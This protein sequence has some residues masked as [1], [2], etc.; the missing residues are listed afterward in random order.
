[1]S[2]YILNEAAESFQQKNNS[3]ETNLK[4]EQLIYR[5]LH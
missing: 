2:S 1:M 3:T 5:E 4:D